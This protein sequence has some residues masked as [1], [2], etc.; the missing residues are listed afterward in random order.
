MHHSPILKFHSLIRAYY[1]VHS[2]HQSVFTHFCR[3]SLIFPYILGDEPAQSTRRTA[4]RRRKEGFTRW[5]VRR[6][7]SVVHI[8]RSRS[9]V[10]SRV[11]GRGSFVAVVSESR[12]VG[13]KFDFLSLSSVSVFGQDRASK[14]KTPTTVVLNFRGYILGSYHTTTLRPIVYLESPRVRIGLT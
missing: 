10:F 14:I 9:Q 12:L 13:R 2:H 3:F 6:N 8:H 7:G 5:S 11:V 1:T 4:I